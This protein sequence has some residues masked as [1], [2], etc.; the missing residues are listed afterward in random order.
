M[1]Y[2]VFLVNTLLGNLFQFFKSWVVFYTGEHKSIRYITLSKEYLG[3][4]ANY[5]RYKLRLAG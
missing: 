4:T 2:L 5:F 3:S 1:K